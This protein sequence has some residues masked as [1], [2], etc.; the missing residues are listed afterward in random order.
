MSIKKKHFCCLEASGD[1]PKWCNFEPRQCDLSSIF[2]KGKYFFP[3]KEL[4]DLGPF[5]VSEKMLESPNGEEQLGSYFDWFLKKIC[6]LNEDRIAE[7]KSHL[8]AFSQVLPIKVKKQKIHHC[9]LTRQWTAMNPFRLGYYDFDSMLPKNHW[10]FSNGVVWT[11][12][13]NHFWGVSI[14]RTGQ[15]REIKSFTNYTPYN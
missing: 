15:L 1:K 12:K 9:A 11:L 10:N 13:N 6:V 7:F 3:C 14:L 2:I 5:S 8:S 4:S